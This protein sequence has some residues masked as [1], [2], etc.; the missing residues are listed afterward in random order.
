MELNE[1]IVFQEFLKVKIVHNRVK[2]W[3]I[4]KMQE[5]WTNIPNWNCEL[6]SVLIGNL[7]SYVWSSWTHRYLKKQMKQ[8][9][10]KRENST[11]SIVM[12]AWTMIGQFQLFR[13]VKNTKKCEE[14]QNESL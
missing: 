8:N 11:I 2:Q 10:M 9:K 3:T 5:R 13:Y 6:F 14:H 4:T 1:F 7:Q 12:L